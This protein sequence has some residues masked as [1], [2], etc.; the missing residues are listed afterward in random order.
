MRM[1]G[2]PAGGPPTPVGDQPPEPTGDPIADLI[3]A[4]RWYQPRHEEYIK[5]DQ[6][7]TEKLLIMMHAAEEYVEARGEPG[8]QEKG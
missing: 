1:A 2:D 3:A 7:F 8:E 5:A 6:A 4:V